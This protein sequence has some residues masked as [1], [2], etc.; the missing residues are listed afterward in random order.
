[1][2]HIHR[3]R[4]GARRSLT[5][6]L[7]A[8]L[9]PL[10]AVATTAAYAAPASPARATAP[11]GAAL[12]PAPQG[13]PYPSVG[14]G[15]HFLDDAALLGNI[16][17][18]SWYEANIPFVDL[19]DQ[20]IQS[21][22]YYRW[23]VWKEHIRPTG[24]ANGDILTEFFGYP[25]YA[26]PYGA[27]DAAAGHHIDE[28]RWVRDQSYLNS[29]ID[30]WLQNAGSGP[31]PATDAVNANQTDWA[32]EYSFWLASAV[33]ARSEVT[34]DWTQARSLLPELVKQYDTWDNQFNPKLGLYWQVPV[35]DAMELSASSYES[36]PS[37]PYHGGAGYRPTL[38]A[39]QYGDAQAISFIAGMAHDT[40][41]ASTFSARAAALRRNMQKWLW[42]PARQFFYDMPAASNPGNQLLSAREE[43]GFVPWMFNMPNGSDSV[44][45][46]QLLDPSGFAAA[47]GPTTV[48]QR[49]NWFMY[50][51]SHGCCHWDGPSWPYA[52]SQTLTAMAN[53]LDNYRQSDVTAA[54][55]D[56][57][58]HTYAATQSENGVPHVGQAH[59]PAQ[60]SWIYDATDYNH[61]SFNDL[62]LSGLLGLRAQTA[63]SL[64]SFRPLVPPSWTYFAVENAP[65]HGHNITVLWDK[66]GTRYSQGRGLHIY[67]D[68]R[69]LASSATLRALNVHLRPDRGAG[70]V[71]AENFT[72][73]AA[74]VYGQGSP[75]P[76]ASYTWQYD[77]TAN[78]T[79]GQIIYDDSPLDSRWTD[80]GS[81][82]ATDD[83]GVDFGAVVPLDEVRI[84][85]YD[86]TANGGD[87]KAPAAY[88][89]QYW[90][91]SAWAD[92][93]GQ[94][95]GPSVPAGD[96]LNRVTFPAITTSQIRV[97]F[98]RQPGY[99]VG[100]SELEAGGASAEAGGI[101]IDGPKAVTVPLKPDQP[102]T[103]TTSLS[104][105]AA[106]GGQGLIT[107][108]VAP[109]G[110]VVQRVGPAQATPTTTWTVT[111]PAGSAG[112]SA[113][114]YAYA[115][116]SQ[117]RELR[118]LLRAGRNV[119]RLLAAALH[120]PAGVRQLYHERSVRLHPGP[121][122]GDLVDRR[123]APGLHRRRRA[124]AG[125]AAHAVLRRAAV[126]HGTRVGQGS[127]GPR[128]QAVPGR[129]HEPGQLVHRVREGR[130]RLRDGLV[131]QRVP[132]I[133]DRPGPRRPAQPARL[134]GAVLR[135]RHPAVRRPLRPRRRRGNGHV[136]CTAHRLGHLAAAGDHVDQPVRR[137]VGPGDP[138]PVP[139]RLRATWRRRHHGRQPL[140]GAS[141]AGALIG[142]ARESS[143][144]RM[145]RP[146]G[147][148]RE[149]S[150]NL[151][152]SLT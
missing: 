83:L 80:Y 30:Y 81:P 112:D 104:G 26:A 58:L 147:P 110:W 102:N 85:T 152:L 32:H 75:S 109:A 13:S 129:R 99:A 1:M 60:P 143:A 123:A 35:W 43:I 67:E 46:K 86:D 113:A 34:G 48:E 5:G 94:I 53:L 78:G 56:A 73:L 126:G 137:P 95:Q 97:V 47:Y 21:V 70:A 8:A 142:A 55:Y 38:N 140:P 146:I 88:T 87:V 108:L 23:N 91:G 93:P 44:A 119:S 54:D 2:P 16:N 124:D 22:Y 100:A 103:I 18:K 68:G 9:L 136:V 17:E 101:W 33:V 144:P 69:L 51:A 121:A 118:H 63:P 3:T 39:Y 150:T 106:A 7:A 105:A 19:P 29:Y 130:R 82:N 116:D 64:L 138:R 50:Q 12:P 24:T 25:G 149:R 128:R 122:G 135:Q 62:V 15:T 42:D 59:D 14:A 76:F 84:Y 139:L 127:L 65:Y 120:R 131:Q 111:P 28:G 90:P 79:D 37:D 74:N 72:D 117:A 92:V 27:I 141:R 6:L 11:L 49:S 20:T 114:L 36:D 133:R 61:S 40:Q 52:T 4:P 71:P 89:V 41:L 132:Y 134:P 98:T 77:S 10:P 125:L 57:L 151:A 31:K 66:D 107:Q 96:D 45:W 115:I 148:L 145:A